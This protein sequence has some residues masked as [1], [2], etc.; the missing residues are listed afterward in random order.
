M[1]VSIGKTASATARGLL[2]KIPAPK[3]LT[4][5]M[6]IYPVDNVAKPIDT[7]FKQSIKQAALSKSVQPGMLMLDFVGPGDEILV[8]YVWKSQYTGSVVSGIPTLPIYEPGSFIV[9]GRFLDKLRKKLTWNIQPM[10]PPIP[11]IDSYKGY[12]N[13]QKDS[14]EAYAYCRELF[15]VWLSLVSKIKGITLT[16]AYYAQAID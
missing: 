11:F 9:E 4:A 10:G 1:L 6:C 15:E 3:Q 14:V 8:T 13:P 12:N 2:K 5:N 16:S 7:Q